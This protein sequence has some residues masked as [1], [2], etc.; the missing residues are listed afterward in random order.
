MNDKL[1]SGPNVGLA[2]TCT[3]TKVMAGQGG[4]YAVRRCRS[5]ESTDKAFIVATCG[6]SHRRKRCFDKI[7]QSIERTAQAGDA[8]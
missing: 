6:D 1:A 5:G 4:G 3:R 7:H 8:V 2:D